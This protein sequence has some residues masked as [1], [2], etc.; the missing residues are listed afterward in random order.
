[1]K[2]PILINTQ[3]F[4]KYSG[5]Q[6]DLEFMQ[7]DTDDGTSGAKLY[8]ENVSKETWDYLKFNYIFDVERIEKLMDNPDFLNDYKRA[9]CIQA[10]Y[11]RKSGDSGLY[12]ELKQSYL[13][14]KAKNIFRGLGL[15]NIQPEH[16]IYRWR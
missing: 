1:M 9:L 4:L 7:G 13:S 6:L 15:M 14:P 16:D 10:E 5:I 11:L 3:E 8:L 2:M 12:P